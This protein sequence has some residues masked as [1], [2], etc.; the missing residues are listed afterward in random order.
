M[1]AVARASGARDAAC[2]GVHA[3]GDERD[4]LVASDA[5]A[6]AQ[7]PSVLFALF[8]L[9]NEDF[10]VRELSVDGALVAAVPPGPPRLPARPQAAAAAAAATPSS[11]PPFRREMFC[12]PRASAVA[13][14]AHRAAF[15]AV[16]CSAR[17][18]CDPDHRDRD[19]EAAEREAERVCAWIDGVCAAV[20]AAASSASASAQ[21]VEVPQLVLARV[22]R[23]QRA[24]LH[25]LFRRHLPYGLVVGVR[26][27]VRVRV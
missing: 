16:L 19:R 23:D 6:N 9:N 20:D 7:S 12:V 8:K 5:A 21:P 3:F 10:V 15:A 18:A 2:A 14:S 24:A 25:V 26:V 27:R 22:D 4:A 17:A 1:Q 13:W 11:Q